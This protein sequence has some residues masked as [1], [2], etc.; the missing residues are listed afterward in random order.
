MGPL[1]KARGATVVRTAWST[2]PSGLG[3]LDDI[4]IVEIAQCPLEN[5]IILNTRF[6]GPEKRPQVN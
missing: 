5:L 2:D 4:G 3:Q 6:I 1:S